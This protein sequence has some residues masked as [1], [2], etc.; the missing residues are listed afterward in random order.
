MPLT[1]AVQMDA[2]DSI[3]VYKDTTFILMLEAQRR[4]HRIWY[5][6]PHQLAFDGVHVTATA[7]PITLTDTREIADAGPTDHF[8]LGQA[9]ILD[10]SQM[11][12]VLMR[13]DPPFDMAYITACH[14]LEHIHPRTLVVNDPKWVRSSP[15]KILPLQWAEYSPPTLISRDPAQLQAFLDDHEDIVLKPLYLFGGTGVIHLRKGH[16]DLEAK[17]EQHYAHHREP[18]VAQRYIP[19]VTEGDTRILL[20]DGNYAG[21]VRRVPADGEFRA[22]LMAGGSAQPA[23]IGN[24]EYA[25][26]EAIGPELARRGLILVGIDLIGGYLTEINTTSPTCMQEI[27]ALQHLKLESDFWDV[28]EQKRKETKSI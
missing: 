25:L 6:E 8:T 7:H 9:E 2:I 14:L 1:I 16:D 20:I 18:L 5:Y 26:C 10:L 15:E 3:A 11:D 28:V 23:D 27:N 22:N 17:I 24:Q 13:Q 12:V 19:E 4:G 21:A